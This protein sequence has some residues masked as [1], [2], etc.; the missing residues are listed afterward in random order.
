MKRGG[1]FSTIPSVNTNTNNNTTTSSSSALYQRS[2]ISNNNSNNLNDRISSPSDNSNFRPI[3]TSVGQQP[4]KFNPSPVSSPT[5]TFPTTNFT[6]NRLNISLT[7]QERNSNSSGVSSG[8]SSSSSI[9]PLV[10]NNPSSINRKNV[11]IPMNFSPIRGANSL[12]RKSW[13]N[14]SGGFCCNLSYFVL[15]IIF[16][17]SFLT[18]I[19]F[20]YYSMKK[21]N[22]ASNSLNSGNSLGGDGKNT[23][24]SE[25]TLILSTV[26]DFFTRLRTKNDHRLK[27]VPLEEGYSQL[28]E[29]EKA[30][31]ETLERASDKLTKEMKEEMLKVKEFYKKTPISKVFVAVVND[32]SQVMSALI[33]AKQERLVPSH[34]S[35]PILHVDSHSGH[36]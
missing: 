8:V 17:I 10:S 30:D 22:S 6:G 18:F 14:S 32:H 12:F 21:S 23:K 24:H 20:V 35:L 26:Q 5:S 2:S 28:F 4:F 34:L 33:V 13:R 36:K 15:G 7:H 9:L 11:N 29:H 3:S 16:F 27:N 1:L 25:S 19:V 31:Q